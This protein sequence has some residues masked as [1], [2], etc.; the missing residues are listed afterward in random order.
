MLPNKL[1]DW[2]KWI[3]LICLPA[4]AVCIRTTF[5]IWNIGY[6]EEISLTI[7]AIDTLLG[8]LLGISSANY[9]KEIK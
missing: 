3:C 6:A 2:L 8:A 5:P 4:L 9:N 7:M 1:Y